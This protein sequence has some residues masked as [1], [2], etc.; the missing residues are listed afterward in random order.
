MTTTEH[1]NHF[2][3]AAELA[4]RPVDRATATAETWGVHYAARALAANAAF[5]DEL[6]DMDDLPP[7]GEEMRGRI[8]LGALVAVATSSTAAALALLEPGTAVG[9]D[10]W[11]LTPECG[12]LNGEYI[13]R[14]VAEARAR[15][16]R[17]AIAEIIREALA[18]EGTPYD[19]Y[20]GAIRVLRGLAETAETKGATR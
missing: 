6:D 16:L 7:A 3:D 2:A 14:L 17:D 1:R 8:D 18:N 11:D 4:P 5:K 9:T 19:S 10:L 15:T 13:D 12:A 20:A